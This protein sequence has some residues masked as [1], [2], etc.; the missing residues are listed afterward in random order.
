M[1]QQKIDWFL[2]RSKDNQ[3]LKSVDDIRSA[4]LQTKDSLFVRTKYSKINRL[5]GKYFPQVFAN[6]ANTGPPAARQ[7][8]R[9]RFVEKV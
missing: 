4:A 6:A 3:P 7:G 9:E 5:I 2:E 1:I 8:V